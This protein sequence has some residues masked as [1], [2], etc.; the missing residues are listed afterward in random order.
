MDPSPVGLGVIVSARGKLSNE[1]V[2]LA[3]LVGLGMLL[4]IVSGLVGAM[5]GPVANTAL[6]GMLFAI[7]VL[8]F[9]AGLG[10]WLALTRPWEQFDDISVPHDTGHH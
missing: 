3:F 1:E 5:F 8:A 10:L 7:G 2:A 6:Y 9:L 4:M